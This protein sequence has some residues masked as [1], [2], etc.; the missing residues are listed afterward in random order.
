VHF[1]FPIKIFPAIA[2]GLAY[3][4]H[5]PFVWPGDSRRC[6]AVSTAR[7]TGGFT[8][9]ELLVVIGIIALLISLLLPTLTVA[10][11]V[12]K[13]TRCAAG[14]HMQLL[15]A[16]VHAAD[17]H[18]FYPVAGVLPGVEPPDFGD[19]DCHKYDYFSYPYAGF[20][21]MLAPI[22][23]SLAS[24]MSYRTLL[25][26]KSNDAVGVAETDDFG[27]IRNFVCASQATSLSDIPQLPMLYISRVTTSWGG[28]A[29]V[30]YTEAMSYM[31]NEAAL[32]WG[33][34]SDNRG[35]GNVSRIHQPART[36]FVADGLG[37]S[38][39]ESRFGYPTGSPM[40]TLYNIASQPPVTMADALTG[41]GLA[42]DPENFDRVRDRG[43]INIG[44]C[45]GH[46]ETRSITASDL[47]NVYLLAP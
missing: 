14:L 34:D 25:N 11:Q 30:W 45:D 31:Y 10:R 21:R 9:V 28:Y 46:V 2:A 38:I 6:R 47:S 13:R 8:L 22:T 32:G 33:Q 24:E 18:G 40:A 4:L 35:R 27:F 15:A 41:D 29:T 44:F 26:V 39:Y 37:G 12:A 23:I 42:G 36:M 3:I 7:S 16:Q 19:N 1:C 5:M 20:T 17:H 43:K